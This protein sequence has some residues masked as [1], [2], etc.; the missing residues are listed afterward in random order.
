MA[1]WFFWFL[2]GIIY[3]AVVFAFMYYFIYLG[4]MPNLWEKYRD[5]FTINVVVIVSVICGFVLSSVITFL[6]RE[7]FFKNKR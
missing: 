2:R 6:T 1:K 7:I 4:A 3:S 5:I